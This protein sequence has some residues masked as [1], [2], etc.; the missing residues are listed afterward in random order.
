MK[1]PVL[2]L[3]EQSKLDDERLAEHMADGASRWEAWE[4]VSIR[5]K[6]SLLA[7]LD[8]GPWRKGLLDMFLAM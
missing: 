7:Q 1:P 8:P 2:N 3:I 6:M 5:R 4:I